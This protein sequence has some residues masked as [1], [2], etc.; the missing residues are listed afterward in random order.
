MPW[1]GAVVLADS[2][3]LVEIECRLSNLA[4]NDRDDPDDLTAPVPGHSKFV[5]ALSPLG[6]HQREFYLVNRPL[7]IRYHNAANDGA[8]ANAFGF[9]Q[10]R[11]SISTARIA[12]SSKPL[13]VVASGRSGAPVPAGRLAS[14]L[15]HALGSHGLHARDPVGQFGSMRRTT[16]SS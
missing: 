1:L 7:Q 16:R 6:T 9:P 13:L 14:S 4:I 3:S 8:T 12:R 10:M 11:R 5:A 2:L 15:A